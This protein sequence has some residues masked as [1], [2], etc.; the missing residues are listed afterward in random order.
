MTIAD[1]YHDVPAG[2]IAAVVTYLEMRHPPAVLDAA[3]PAGLECRRVLNPDLGWYRQLFRSIGEQ[4]LWFSRAVMSDEKLR[5]VIHSEQV[6][7]YT[8]EQNGEAKGLLELDLRTF[9][10]IEISLFG[11]TSD[12]IGKGVGRFLI[13]HAI[14]QA[15]RRN[16]LRLFLHTCTLDHPGALSFYRKAGFQPYKRAIEIA[17]DPRVHGDTPAFAAP[18]IPIL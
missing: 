1:G 8:L 3:L 6:E 2:R 7:V 14:R 9:P 10:D 18:Q 12:W 16:P 17:P 4:W 13:Q 11:L 15:F 5:A